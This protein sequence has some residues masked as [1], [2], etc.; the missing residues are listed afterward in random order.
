LTAPVTVTLRMAFNPLPPGQLVLIVGVLSLW[1][2]ATILLAGRAFRLNL[3][4]Y[5]KRLSLR[6]LF[7]RSR[8]TK[9]AS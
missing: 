6:A 5:G 1:A 8:P 3:L 4:G 9:V 2:V 7:R